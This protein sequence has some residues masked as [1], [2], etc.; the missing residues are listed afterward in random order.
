M[1]DKLI[2]GEEGVAL[3]I[4]LMILMATILLGLASMMIAST[5][6]RI[7]RN[8]GNSISAFY[9]AEAGIDRSITELRRDLEW[10][11]GFAQTGLSNQSTYE[12]AVAS[13]DTYRRNI[14]STGH[15]GIAERQ[16]E[17]VI[18]IDS[19]FRHALNAGG[20]I[21]LAGKPR[22]SVEGIRA[23]GNIHLELDA[24]TPTL[25]VYA[26][27]G[28]T[29]TIEGDDTN[30]HSYESPPMDMDAVRLEPSEWED[31]AGNASGSYYRDEDG[32]FNSKDSDTT[33]NDFNCESI[34]PDDEG[35]RTL[36]VDGDVTFMGSLSG[37]C[38]VVA[39]GKIIG[40]GG[41]KTGP[42]TTV[43]MIAMDDVLLNYDTEAQ[44]TMN[45]LVYTEGDYELHGKINFT[46][47]VTAFGNLNL[48]NPSEFTN[49]SDPNFWYTYSSAYSIIADPID[50]LSWHEVYRG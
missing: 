33:Y 2:R 36:F 19:V 25:N 49:N 6:I 8:Y 29:V 30:V 13:P 26:P 41:F 43:S 22:I 28:S 7:S 11:A 12:V 23:N 42:G 3:V 10:N 45:G 14:L 44:S 34:T 39:T 24:G 20:D 1:F 40:T 27:E 47:V 17:M 46:G 16:I 48:Q 38:T 4:V 32:V 21:I 18:N 50:I 15:F 37:T 31:M 5:D 9:A 35:R